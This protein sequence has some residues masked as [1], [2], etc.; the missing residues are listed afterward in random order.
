MN[1]P[2]REPPQNDS[3]ILIVTNVGRGY[4][5]LSDGKLDK[6]GLAKSIGLTNN[7][8]KQINPWGKMEAQKSTGISRTKPVIAPTSPPFSQYGMGVQCIHVSIASCAG[9]DNAC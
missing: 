8:I 6:N 2:T 9:L 3:R 7:G 5:S 4:E 1:S